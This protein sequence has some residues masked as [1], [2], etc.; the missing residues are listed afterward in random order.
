MLDYHLHLW[1]HGERDRQPRVEEL[2]AYWDRARSAGVTE[3]ALTEHLFRFR[4]ADALL[5]GWWEEEG[6]DP[7]LRASAA[8]YWQRH[9][10]ADL[11]EYVATVLDAKAAGLPVALGLEV[12]YYRGRM[13]QVAALLSGYP[14]DVLLGSVHWLG[15]WLF[16]DLSDE[17]AQ[18]EWGRRGVEAAWDAY[19]EALCELAASGVCDVLA[20]PDL[21]KVAG[22]RPPDLHDRYQR[23][24]E[25]AG[26]HGMAA[27]VS[28]AGWRKPAL[29]AYPAP[30]LLERFCA[31]GVPVTTASDAHGLGDVADRAG[32]LAGLVRGAGYGSLT[33]F[34][35]RQPVKVDIGAGGPGATFRP[36]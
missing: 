13:D 6:G 31:L 26:A 10:G 15:P 12:D 24:A 20:H 28:S 16:D 19:T 21:A 7:A 25:A 33:A 29:E 36:G 11:D 23:M 5:G 17:V 1:P 35:A 32:E 30:E 14:F 8:S 34:R 2:A 22:H 27:E 4:Q 3:I 18:A 9:V